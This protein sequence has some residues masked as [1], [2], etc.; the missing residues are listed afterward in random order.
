LTVTTDE[1]VRRSK[2]DPLESLVSAASRPK[3]NDLERASEILLTA[4][5]NSLHESPKPKLLAL[6]G[7][8]DSR[9]IA[10]AMLHIG[11][12]PVCYT[13]GESNESDVIIANALTHS[14]GLDWQQFDSVKIEN[15]VNEKSKLKEIVKSFAEYSL[16]STS[17]SA[18]MRRLPI[19][20]Y[21]DTHH[22]IDGGFGEIFRSR[23]LLKLR[24]L[25]LIKSV[26]SNDIMRHLLVSRHTTD[27][28]FKTRI[29]QQIRTIWNKTTKLSLADRL[30]IFSIATRLRHFGGPEHRRLNSF[31]DSSMPF[32]SDYLLQ[33]MFEIHPRLRSSK[34]FISFCIQ[35]WYPKWGGIPF[36]KFG[37][38]QHLYAPDIFAK[39]KKSLLP[40]NSKSAS[41]RNEIFSL[42]NDEFDGLWR[43]HGDFGIFRPKSTANPKQLEDIDYPMEWL[44]L[45]LAVE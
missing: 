38:S 37:H 13:L 34:R 19:L 36:T 14:A 45:A 15:F 43:R 10:A 2:F 42:F 16:N 32:A 26:D 4:V 29:D 7:G 33:N 6:S 23:Y 8:I 35:K 25:N 20:A 5:K 40:S 9:L 12:R 18:S 30:D 31:I 3:V 28:Q 1:I 39:I 24:Y 11:E 27:V 41:Y 21:S 44:T 22:L 17:L